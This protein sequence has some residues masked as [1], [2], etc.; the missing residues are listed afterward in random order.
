M[1]LVQLRAFCAHEVVVVVVVLYVVLIEAAHSRAPP[2]VPLVRLRAFYAHEVVVM[3]VVEELVLVEEVIVV[4][5]IKQIDAEHVGM[6]R[7][8]EFRH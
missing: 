1:P 5:L 4:C 7:F 6:T 3:A 8:A 2:T